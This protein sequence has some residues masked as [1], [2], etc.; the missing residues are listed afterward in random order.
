M[1]IVCNFKLLFSTRA[2][3]LKAFYFSNNDEMTIIL[4]VLYEIRREKLHFS[5]EAI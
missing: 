2:K 4:T 5:I 1:K 3:L